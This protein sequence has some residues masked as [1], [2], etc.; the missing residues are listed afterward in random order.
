VP[1]ALRVLETTGAGGVDRTIARG[2]EPVPPRLMALIV[3]EN[4]PVSVG[5]PEIMPLDGSTSS[6]DGRLAGIRVPS[7]AA[8]ECL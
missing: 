3:A 8:S 7:L 1:V 2:A 6:P 5:V 4:D